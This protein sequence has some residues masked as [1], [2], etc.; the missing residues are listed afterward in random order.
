MEHSNG[1]GAL[2]RFLLCHPS[3]RH[4]GLFPVSGPWHS[5]IHYLP[6]MPHYVLREMETRCPAAGS[7][8]EEPKANNLSQKTSNKT[9]LS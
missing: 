4:S 9:K 8:E 3:P 2:V 5:S 1:R 7:G 6:R